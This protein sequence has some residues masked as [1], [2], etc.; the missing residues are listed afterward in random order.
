M[1][2]VFW[3]DFGRYASIITADEDPEYLQKRRVLPIFVEKNVAIIGL[4]CLELKGITRINAEVRKIEIRS[5]A[6]Y[7]LIVLLTLVTSN[8]VIDSLSSG[9]F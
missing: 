6:Q 4:L 7:I 1:Q 9:V 5:K 8:K 2:R 3:H